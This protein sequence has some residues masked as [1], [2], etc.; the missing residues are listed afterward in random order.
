M[1]NELGAIVSMPYLKMKFPVLIGEIV[2]VKENQKHARQ[3]Y[4]E[5]LK[6]TPYPP[7]REPVRPHPTVSGDTQVMSVDKEFLV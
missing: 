5:S 4:A 1:V 3:C 7:T 6:V 2:T